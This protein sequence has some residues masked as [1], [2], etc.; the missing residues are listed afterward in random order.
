MT[1]DGMSPRD[2]AAA[3]TIKR[4][5]ID[6][7]ALAAARAGERQP[8]QSGCN[9][10]ADCRIEHQRPPAG[11]GSVP[12]GDDLLSLGNRLALGLGALGSGGRLARVPVLGGSG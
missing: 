6:R 7:V 8:R 3:V 1:I 10:S 4:P 11:L 12:D 2:L 5:Q 9:R